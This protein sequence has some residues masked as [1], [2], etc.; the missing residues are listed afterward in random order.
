MNKLPD[1]VTGPTLR[2]RPRGGRRTAQRIVPALSLAFV[3]LLTTSDPATAQ[4]RLGVVVG[5]AS[6]I[7]GLVEY[8]WEHQ[9]LELQ[10]G[11]LPVGGR[12]LS[13]SVTAKQYMKAN[14]LEPYVGAGVW[15]LVAMA[16]EGVGHALVARVPVGLDWNLSSQQAIGGALYFNRILRVKRP[17]PLDMRPSTTSVIPL[18]ELFSYRWFPREKEKEK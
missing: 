15:W 1:S 16:E 12:N 11:T 6:L 14:R 10:I 8:R 17:D 13:V 18:P 2:K 9:G 3:A 4:Y 7:G 5:G